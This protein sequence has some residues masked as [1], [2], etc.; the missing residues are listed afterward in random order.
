MAR[1][2]VEAAGD[3]LLPVALRVQ[4]QLRARRAQEDHA[5]RD[6]LPPP[7]GYRTGLT[8]QYDSKATSLRQEMDYYI[9]HLRSAARTKDQDL[10]VYAI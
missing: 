2:V 7:A 10:A 4:H 1:R 8:R 3:D 5:G 6:L 9:V